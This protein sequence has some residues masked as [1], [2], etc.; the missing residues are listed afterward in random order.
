MTHFNY[1]TID[2]QTIIEKSYSDHF[3]P[4]PKYLLNMNF[5]NCTYNEG[6]WNTFLFGL[7]WFMHIVF[8]AIS[9]IIYFI[10]GQN[11]MWFWI[12]WSFLVSQNFIYLV[13]GLVGSSLPEFTIRPLPRQ[14]PYESLE[15][16]YLVEAPSQN[17]NQ[18]I[19]KEIRLTRSTYDW[20]AASIDVMIIGVTLL[21]LFFIIS[22]G[23][24][25][26][27]ISVCIISL[28]VLCVK[29]IILLRARYLWTQKYNHYSTVIK[30]NGLV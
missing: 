29:Q 16:D 1:G 18:Y 30:G 20:I 3:D 22:D 17:T 8:L 6:P 27:N 25:N 19:S 2:N 10:D 21:P 11:S 4:M 28:A 13:T 12:L 24:F 15:I 23:N 14:S 9:L 7:S 5:G 26:G